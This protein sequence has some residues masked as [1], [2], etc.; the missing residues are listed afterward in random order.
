[1]K[2]SKIAD[3][4][5]L[6]EF[7]KLHDIQAIP[8]RM[9]KDCY[10]HWWEKEGIKCRWENKGIEYFA[11]V[12]LINGCYFLAFTEQGYCLY[13]QNPQDYW[14]NLVRIW[15]IG[16]PDDVFVQELK[17]FIYSDDIHS[18]NSNVWGRVRKTALRKNTRIPKT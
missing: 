17:G 5:A 1:V 16:V 9:V 15:E 6:I 2:H 11:D 4:K 8:T 10:L 7:L 3:E 14:Y 12:A 18:A 13:V